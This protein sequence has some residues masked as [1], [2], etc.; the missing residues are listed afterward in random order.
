MYGSTLRESR[1]G[2]WCATAVLAVAVWAGLGAGTGNTNIPTD[3]VSRDDLVGA[4]EREI[5]FTRQF[6]RQFG[7]HVVDLSSG[8]SVYSLEADRLHIIASN[9]KLFTTAAAL[10]YLGPGHFFETRLMQRG[11]LADRVLSGDIA[12]IGGGDPNISGRHYDGD[13][14]AIF[15]RWAEQIRSSGIDR[16]SGDLYLVDGLF[17]SEIVHRD[18]PRD[19]MS[20]WYQAPVSA[21]SF[22]DNCVL[23]RVRPGSRPGAPAIVE[24]VPDLDMFEVRNEATTTSSSKSHVVSIN[25]LNG[26]NVIQVKG[27]IYRSAAP[28]ESWVT[29]ADPVEYF[30]A[31]LAKAL[32]RGGV[33]F[34]GSIRRIRDLPPGAWTE[35]LTHRIDLVSTIDVINKRSQNFYAESLLK[36]M[37][38]LLCADGS[39]ASGIRIVQDFL[40]TVG[41]ERGAYR[42]ADGSGMSRNN[43]FTARQLTR[44]LHH[45]FL[46]PRASEFVMSLPYS[47]EEGLSW[48][49]RL[50]EPEYRA[51]VFAKS[52]GLRGVSTLSGYAKAASGRVY[53]FSILCNNN[54][55]RWEAKRAQ[56]RIVAALID[57]G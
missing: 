3:A 47:G 49:K 21:L 31:A 4:I 13:P 37:G 41:I 40:A 33:E 18:W 10:E 17:E 55:S 28:V 7:V 36:L 42:L 2:R 29:V 6:S 27:R 26:S 45:M 48:E 50:A 9:T 19:Q 30:G 14:L 22:S 32:R 51:N 38:A 43:Q 16:I 53:A 54:T 34:A 39:W 20:R 44:L 56:D 57:N 5:R 52:G 25:R 1:V 11:D 12:V 23:V 8:E 15:S 24:T 35:T 46:H